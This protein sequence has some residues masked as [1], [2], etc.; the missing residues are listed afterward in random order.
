M[1][2]PSRLDIEVVKAIRAPVPPSAIRELVRRAASLPEVRARL[3][4]GRTSVAYRLTGDEELRRLNRTYLQHDAVTDVLS[5]AGSGEH[6]GDVAVSWPEVVRQAA[7]FGHPETTELG[8]LC[9]HGLL[10]LLGWDHATQAG[11]REM[12]RL[13][14]E[15]L[16][17]SGLRP[18]AR[19]L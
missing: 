9:V 18:A 15:A 12:S 17:L 13:T 8:L 16:R 19:R 7:A 3:P 10:H 2:K 1:I 6:L 14:V 5:F 11:R 4:A